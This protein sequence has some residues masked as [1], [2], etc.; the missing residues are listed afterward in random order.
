MY[1][2]WRIKRISLSTAVKIGGAV[3]CVMGFIIGAVACFVMA[4]FSSLIGNV[5][6]ENTVRLGFAMLV[7]SPF[8]FAFI[9]GFLGIAFSFLFALL[10]N[11]TSGILGGVKIE[12]NDEE[13]YEYKIRMR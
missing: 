2:Q 7:I 6:S 10:Y 11:L 9:C 3:S 12:V 13:K 1:K 5:L 8:L 4:F